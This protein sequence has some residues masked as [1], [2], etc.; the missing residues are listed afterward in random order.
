MLSLDDDRW[1]ELDHRSWANGEPCGMD[2]PYIP[3]ELKLLLENPRDFERF[4]TM[5]PY[6]SSENTTWEASYAAMP[7][8]LVI[9]RRLSPR[10]RADH[11]ISIGFIAWNATSTARENV[12]IKPLLPDY[13]KAL[14]EA[15]P[16]LAETILEEHSAS[17]TRYL[18]ATLAA[19]KGHLD[20]GELISD[21][22]FYTACPN[23]DE[24]IFELNE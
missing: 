17:T 24:K 2:A 7:Y 10:E 20:L 6:L 5:A 15:L 23:C 18:L 3:A 16:L 8:I 14:R 1:K 22:V 12:T 19:L 9:A 13:D 4:E 21:L 11:L